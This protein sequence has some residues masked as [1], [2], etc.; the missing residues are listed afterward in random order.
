MKMG[1]NPNLVPEKSFEWQ[2]GSFLAAGVYAF[3]LGVAFVLAVKLRSKG[4][5][6]QRGK[7]GLSSPARE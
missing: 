7:T 2:A 4:E 1:G 5:T 6:D 3:L